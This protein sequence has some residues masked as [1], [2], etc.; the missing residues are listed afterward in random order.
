LIA[1]TGAAFFCAVAQIATTVTERNTH[2]IYSTGS[3]FFATTTD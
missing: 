2:S 3:G 1:E